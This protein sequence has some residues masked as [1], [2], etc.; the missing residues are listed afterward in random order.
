MRVSWS[1]GCLM[2]PYNDRTLKAALEA[3]DCYLAGK[4]AQAAEGP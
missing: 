4:K 3:V 2:K 1:I